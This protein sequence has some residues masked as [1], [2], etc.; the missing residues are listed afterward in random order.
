MY[1]RIH[2]KYPNLMADAIRLC[3]A[4]LVALAF[5]PDLDAKTATVGGVIFTLDSGRVQTVWPNVRVTL[6]SLDT[7]N[8]V[9]TISDDLGTYAFTGVLYGTMKS[10]SRWLDLSQSPGAWR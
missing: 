2:P 5:E 3:V 9:A 8:E 1:L 10:L 4:I 7:N 6:K